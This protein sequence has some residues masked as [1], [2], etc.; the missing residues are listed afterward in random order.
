MSIVKW[1]QIDGNILI[2]KND[3]LLILYEFKDLLTKNELKVISPEIFTSIL[4]EQIKKVGK[5]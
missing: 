1:T 2:D 4:I 3:L 5:I